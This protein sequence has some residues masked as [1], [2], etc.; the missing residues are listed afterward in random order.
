ML[1]PPDQQNMTERVQIIST[2][3]KFDLSA[4]TYDNTPA[5]YFEQ[6]D[7]P[8]LSMLGDVSGK[9]ILDVGCG[10]G[11]LLKKLERMGANAVGIDISKQ[12]VEKAKSKS[13]LAFQTDISDF[14]WSEPFDVVVS[15]LTFNYIEDKAAA[16]EKIWSLLKPGGTFIISLDLLTKDTAMRRGKDSVAAKYFPLSRRQYC[17]LLKHAGYVMELSVDLFW[18]D[19]FKDYPNSD[20]PIGFALETGKPDGGPI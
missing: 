18:S 7:G 2:S 8:V 5:E 12:M 16:F 13:L 20:L 3:E 1:L 9:A 11:R 19:R 15:V 17:G 14:A 4:P 6:W 10:T